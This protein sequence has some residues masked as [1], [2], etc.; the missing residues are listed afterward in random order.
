MTAIIGTDF[1]SL[2]TAYEAA[3][4]SCILVDRSGLGMLKFSGETRLDLINRMSTQKVLDLQSG[5]GAATVLTTDIGRIIDRIILYTSN[6]AVYCLT[7][8]DN[9][10]NIARYLMRFVFFMDDFQVEELSDDTAVLAVYGQE[11]GEK[12]AS[13]F[14][15][16]SGLPLHHWRQVDLNGTT[17]YLHRTDPVA[18]NGFFITCPASDRDKVWEQLVGTGF[19]PASQEAFDYLRIESGLPRFGRELTQDY[20]PLEA[21]LWDDVSFNKGCYTGQEI[22]ARMES[23]GRL[24]KKLVRLVAAEHVDAGA[25]LR[26][27]GKLA[28]AITSAANGPNGPLALGYV[29]SAFIEGNTELTAGEIAVKIA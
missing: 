14:E 18:G 20:I 13:F 24:A 6:D 9:G 21:N 19:V 23:R 2:D 7:G 25:D 15:D 10:D 1:A 11:A 8:E 29:K 22:I 4:H 28:G 12:L 3:H 26:A 27:K 17:L 5:Q 16:A